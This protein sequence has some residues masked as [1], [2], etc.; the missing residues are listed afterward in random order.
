MEESKES[1][2][3]W[4]KPWT[5]EE[6]RQQSANWNLAGDAGLLRHLQQFS[7]NLLAQTHATEVALDSLI[8]QLK[9]TSTDVS[10]VTNQFLCLANTQF[11]EN[12]VYDDDDKETPEEKKE[13]SKPKTKEE[14]EAEVVAR[15]R[16]ALALGMSVLDTMFDTVDVPASD[17]EDEE[18]AGRV[19][20]EPHNPYLNRPLPY[21][22]GSRQ[23]MEDDHVGLGSPSDSEENGADLNLIQ[24]SESESEMEV[25]EK[26]VPKKRT[27]LSSSSASVNS[28][29]E[30]SDSS[31]GG[32]PAPGKQKKVES[33]G[34][35]GNVPPADTDNMFGGDSPTDECGIID[36]I[37]PRDTFAAELAAKLGGV[38]AAA[39]TDSHTTE[40]Q[41]PSGNKPTLDWGE[42]EDGNGLFG[43]HVGK[44]SGG[45]G[46]F[47]DLENSPGSL[48]DTKA[49]KDK[50]KISNEASLFGPDAVSEDDIFS[51]GVVTEKKTEKNKRVQSVAT[52]GVATSTPETVDYLSVLSEGAAGVSN[53]KKSPI[54]DGADM[55]D[56]SGLFAAPK[57]APRNSVQV[58]ADQPEAPKKKK[59]TGG[60]SIF[61]SVDMFKAGIRRPPSSSSCSSEG[62]VPA[63][64][65]GRIFSTEDTSSGIGKTA[66]IDQQEPFKSHGSV[67]AP[68]IG[69]VSLFGDGD[70]DGDGLFDPVP[71]LKTQQKSEK[72]GTSNH[73]VTSDL[74]QDDG[75]DDSLFSKPQKSLASAAKSTSLKPSA[76]SRKPVSLFSDSDS[77][78][79]EQL[80]SHASSSS[81]RRSQGSG[82][83][84]AASGDKI[85]PTTIQK[86]GLFENEDELFS[87]TKDEPKFDIF[88]TGSDSIKSTSLPQGN[89]G[90]DDL[91]EKKLKNPGFNLFSP[92]ADI[93]GTVKDKS[94]ISGKDSLFGDGDDYGDNFD[95]FGGSKSAKNTKSVTNSS[96]IS[97]SQSSVKDSES[98]KASWSLFSDNT[99]GLIDDIFAEPVNKHKTEHTPSKSTLVD[100]LFSGGSVLED[101]IDD[102]FASDVKQKKQNDSQ[103]KNEF[104]DQTDDIFSAHNTASTIQDSHETRSESK[105]SNS[106]SI[107]KSD[108]VKDSI[109]TNI[110]SDNTGAIDLFSDIQEESGSL[111]SENFSSQS[112]TKKPV[113]PSKPIISPKPKI[114][115]AP[116]PSLSQE[117]PIE[118]RLSSSLNS[119]KDISENLIP[120]ITKESNN[121]TSVDIAS[122]VSKKVTEK[123]DKIEVLQ[124]PQAD[125]ITSSKENSITKENITQPSKLEPP[126][127]LNIRK[128]TGLQFNSSSNEDEDLFGISFLGKVSSNIS[129]SEPVEEKP[130]SNFAAVLQSSSPDVGKP[131]PFSTEKRSKSEKEISS[132]VES[133]QE[134][135]SNSIVKARS[136]G[137]SPRQ[138]NIDPTA[139]LP[140]ARPLPKTNYNTEVAVSFDHPAQFSA[141]LHSAGKERARIQAKRRPP[142]RKARQEAVRTSG[143]GFEDFNT[144]PV[145]SAQKV[146]EPVREEADNLKKPGTQT[147]VAPEVGFLGSQLPPDSP[148]KPHSSFLDNTNNLLSPSTD[149]EDLFGVPQDLPSEYGNNKDDGQSLFSSAPVLSP[150]EFNSESLPKLS[151]ETNSAAEEPQNEEVENINGNDMHN[152]NNMF[153][154]SLI[155]VT[156]LPTTHIFSSESSK[157]DKIGAFHSQ[158]DDSSDLFSESKKSFSSS[159]RE[160]EDLFDSKTDPDS[161]FKTVKLA[162]KLDI[163]SYLLEKKETLSSP[164]RNEH[165]IVKD[166]FSSESNPL[167]LDND[168]QPVPQNIPE[169]SSHEDLFNSGVAKD[170]DDLFV[171]GKTTSTKDHSLFLSAKVDSVVIHS[172]DGDDLFSSGT[173][174]FVSKQNYRRT[175]ADKSDIFEPKDID[176][177][178]LFIS[179]NKQKQPEENLFSNTV[180]D[181]NTQKFATVEKSSNFDLFGGD[182][183]ESDDLF[184]SASSKKK[185]PTALP[186]G[187]SSSITTKGSLFEEDESDDI[188]GAIK[189]SSKAISS[190][191]ASSA[192][193][194]TNSLFTSDSATKKPQPKTSKPTGSSSSHAV[195]ED[196]DDL[197][198]DPLM[199]VMKK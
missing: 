170:C 71:T 78:E 24:S 6:M 119:S 54:F 144:A 130:T 79:D 14:Q 21:L 183:P 60:V 11:L 134:S 195:T 122:S 109:F 187:K 84:L 110:S 34:L 72:I 62:S 87:G 104:D 108:S 131:Q 176:D 50:K 61:G 103:S 29:F 142:S 153:E 189:P 95:I 13:E 175:S 69:K 107:N 59:P 121:K 197:F 8:E 3:P 138:L 192:F 92:S 157:P 83:L 65:Q 66:S 82:D 41:R 100:S 30:A 63:N 51:E 93:S 116:K 177:N 162:P 186:K 76:P 135:G 42:D 113:I 118:S 167:F 129:S 47:D 19:V 158:D 45:Q 139:L 70:G 16:E 169:S 132:K 148:S 81:S 191:P 105:Y 128:T 97:N 136:V 165:P 1:V 106:E 26:N 7:Q 77:G 73:T 173:K 58:I 27:R 101:K 125:V 102:L 49:G 28:D 178:A 64:E 68:V 85:R 137:A 2:K 53:I 46:L 56:D 25:E 74:F 32:G 147:S 52:S 174:T 38:A 115:P 33:S 180:K 91:F 193:D 39:G 12:R 160:K 10:N 140:G 86:K 20:L 123:L 67:A 9:A 31:S 99:E 196:N 161:L 120:N 145:T 146:A 190:K 43:G 166:S 94:K 89:G 124:S 57:P 80:F 194:N 98:A 4:E 112:I 90:G 17:S 184:F 199:V 168:R 18:S 127:T 151:E 143:I 96:V 150:L 179:G 182:S 181:G 149:E 48:W 55:E 164:I 88:N 35:F 133:S 23:F 154:G 188:F 156:P 163:S 75:T 159:S 37:G 5:T 172:D 44:F 155:K 117:S 114:S 141:T 111:F 36:G 198:E 152:T 15:V 40:K 185:L 171:S 22:I 126:K